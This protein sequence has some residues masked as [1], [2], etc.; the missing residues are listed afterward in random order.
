MATFIDFLCGAGGSS[1]GLVEAGLELVLGVNHW[2]LALETHA[3]NHRNADHLCID[4]SGMP[5]RYL[6]KADVL[7]ASVICTEISPAGGRPRETAQ[8]DLLDGDDDFKV[9]PDDAF[10]RTR[11]T[12][13]CVVRAVEVHRY[14]AI[15]VENVLE[16]VTDWILFNQWIAA[17]KGLGYNYQITSVSSAHVG[18]DDN[19][20]APQWR[21]RVYITFTR[22]GMRKPDLTPSPA[23]YCF[24]CGENVNAVQTWRDP[25]I[26]VGK[27]SKQY[28]YRC[29]NSRCHHA[30]VEPWVR[31]ASA[32][33]DWTD[34]GQRIGSRRK[35]LADTTMDRIRAGLAK[36]PHVPSAISLT[37]G[38][39][40]GDRAFGL[41]DR[42][43]PTRSTKQGEAMLVPT[44][45]SWNTDP[46]P[47]SQPLRT[48][49]TRES[50]AL[51]TSPSFVIEYRNNASG[52]SIH[53]PL[54]TVTAQGNHHGLVLPGGRV[55]P[56]DRNTLVVPYRKSATKHAG[57]PFHTLSTKDS[58][59][60]VVTEESIADCWF[61]MLKP[62]EQLAG[63]RFPDTYIVL[64]S[65]A[66]RTMQAG[67]AVSVN[68]AQWIGRKLLEVL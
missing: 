37:H 65:G 16:F 49:T 68:V 61:R 13:W 41:T 64:G 32:A 26:T 21:D 14:R 7:W 25:K 6:P 38:R 4:V 52:S 48:R 63:Q 55:D 47:V 45:G 22:R 59:A 10:E 39:D 33:I 60:V 1:T 43:L 31:P 2:K 27:Y 28:D 40:G 36:F 5:M 54:S 50:E 3:A 19:L 53:S 12:A 34:L 30:I 8:L 66:E 35:P 62:E 58:A 15:V 67:N 18:D 20:R 51:L 17:M 57:M 11:V 42:P 46:Y 9:L 29:P 56:R 44:G 24:V 23:A